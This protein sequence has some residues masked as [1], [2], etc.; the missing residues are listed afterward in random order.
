MTCL[1][2]RDA[3]ELGGKHAQVVG[4]SGFDLLTRPIRLAIVSIASNKNSAL[5][6]V[7][8]PARTAMLPLSNSREPGTCARARTTAKYRSARTRHV[9]WLR[10]PLLSQFR[11]PMTAQPAPCRLRPS[12]P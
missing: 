8:N 9:F 1:A 10:R 12:R 11:P 7:R 4:D 3:G 5:T 6:L 2:V